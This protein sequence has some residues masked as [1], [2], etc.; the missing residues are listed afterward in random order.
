MILICQN[1]ILWTN[2]HQTRFSKM[3][4]KPDILDNLV[5][6]THHTHIIIR[7]YPVN[8]STANQHCI[9]RLQQ[10]LHRT[11][12]STVHTR[13]EHLKTAVLTALQQGTSAHNQRS[14]FVAASSSTT[15]PS[16]SHHPPSP[17]PPPPHIKP[18]YC[19]PARL[20]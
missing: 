7:R 2:Q 5:L 8:T 1:K 19:H 14:A 15:V 16:C 17:P 3:V 20:H 9:Q 6:H 12:A 13:T 18:K 11:S 4:Y 10:F